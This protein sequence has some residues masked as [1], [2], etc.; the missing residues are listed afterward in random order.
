MRRVRNFL[1]QRS[2]PL[3]M[4]RSIVLVDTESMCAASAIVTV[5][6]GRGARVLILGANIESFEVSHEDFPHVAAKRLALV[7]GDLAR[8]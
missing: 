3:A 4:R 6:L 2:S 8:L 1:L 5:S 7:G